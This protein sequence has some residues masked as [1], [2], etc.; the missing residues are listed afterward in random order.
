MIASLMSTWSHALGWM[1]IHFLWQGLA[2]AAALWL[3]LSMIPRRRCAMRYNVSILA[4]AAVC[5]LPIGTTWKIVSSVDEGG[6]EKALV[7]NVVPMQ[8]PS[9]IELPA[10]S[11]AEIDLARKHEM[12]FDFEEGPSEKSLDPILPWLVVFWG[13]GLLIAN[14]RLVRSWLTLLRW[15]QDGL[16]PTQKEW[17]VRFSRLAGQLAIGRAT[18]L[19]ESSRVSVPM[20]IGWAKPVVLIPIGFLTSLPASQIDAILLHELAHVRRNDFLVNVFQSCVETFFYFHPA[21]KWIGKQI[22]DEREYCCDQIAVEACGDRLCYAKSLAALEE[23]R[24]ASNSLGV[25]ANSGSLLKRIRRLSSQEAVEAR[26]FPSIAVSLVLA[27]C[28]LAA[29][30]LTPAAQ[31]EV[32]GQEPVV[33]D[34]IELVSSPEVNVDGRPALLIRV[35]DIDTGEPIDSVRA[36][37]GVPIRK[38]MLN[39]ENRESDP[40][41]QWVNW[42]SHTSRTFDGGEVHWLLE[43][44]YQP[45]CLRVEAA[46]YVAQQ[47]STID[48][49]K[50][51]QTITFRLKK[52]LGKRGQVMTPDGRPAAGA[53]VGIGIASRQLVVQDGSFRGYK[54]DPSN[55]L[56]DEWN[57]PWI[58]KADDEGR[59]ILPTEVDPSA[60]I[61]AIHEQG[62]AHMPYQAMKLGS[63]IKLDRWGHL[64][65]TVLVGAEPAPNE[66]VSIH[67]ELVRGYPNPIAYWVDMVSDESGKIVV[68]HVPR[69][70]GEWQLDEFL[71]REDRPS[72]NNWEWPK[73]PEQSMG[74]FFIKPGV[75]EVVTFGGQALGESN[76]NSEGQFRI[77]IDAEG[78]LKINGKSIQRSQLPDLQSA[79]SIVIN[80]EQGADYDEVMRV[81]NE[82]FDAHRFNL[83]FSLASG[84]WPKRND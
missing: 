26:R 50:G 7:Q 62:I 25:A 59:F 49:E 32:G 38:E 10:N 18:R 29:L 12:N 8:S 83:Y 75:T 30:L 81:Y 16:I 45:M 54:G 5:L 1:L 36:V 56:S 24:I 28:L 11:V 41:A 73:L 22:R 34:E 55:S 13:I 76:M 60:Q 77:D 35:L 3:G 47:Y 61:A 80:P 69:G 51:P 15:K 71:P 4:L 66:R 2:V 6:N 42:Q 72:F 48:P 74:N 20:V 23:S 46:G 9:S 43:R 63:D 84:F 40:D 17:N 67:V 52:D 19:L 79:V 33:E 82:Y 58:V 31:A 64:E 14:L 57:T 65:A 21:V 70:S 53:L 27:T 44:A 37:A 78:N 39:A 68:D